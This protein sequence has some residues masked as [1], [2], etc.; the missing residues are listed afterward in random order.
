MSCPGASSGDRVGMATLL[1]SV[2]QF[3]LE[4]FDLPLGLFLPHQ[5]NT[6]RLVSR[7]LSCLVRIEHT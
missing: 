2:T 6:N 5:S 3:I 4:P 1:T 7:F